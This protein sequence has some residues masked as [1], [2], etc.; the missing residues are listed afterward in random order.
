MSPLSGSQTLDVLKPRAFEFA[1]AQDR[2]RGSH[3][4]AVCQI[5]MPRAV[6]VELSRRTFISGL[7]GEVSIVLGDGF[8][9]RVSDIFTMRCVLASILRFGIPFECEWTEAVQS[10][11]MHYRSSHN[12]SS[13]RDRVWIAA[14][15][16]SRNL[17]QNLSFAASSPGEYYIMVVVSVVLHSQNSQNWACQALSSYSSWCKM[18]VFL[19]PLSDPNHLAL[20]LSCMK[21]LRESGV[22][23][24]QCFWH[25]SH[26]CSCWQA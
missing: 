21:L 17:N 16:S 22:R 26:S 18:L 10:F 12:D 19:S 23:F 20:R 8:K 1:A 11:P 14:P 3:T 9:A 15:S 13:R 6:T 25:A 24:L 4:S 7:L 2:H 5:G